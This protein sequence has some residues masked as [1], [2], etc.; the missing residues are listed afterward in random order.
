MK[1]S[2]TFENTFKTLNWPIIRLIESVFFLESW[3]D[4]GYFL[5]IEEKASFTVVSF[6][7]CERGSD[8]IFD[9]SLTSLGGTG[10]PKKVHKFKIIY[11]CSENRQI[12]KLCFIYKTRPQLKF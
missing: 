6:T 7:S 9:A 5:C 1:R 4:T 10:C 12:T 3:S 11:L 2:K 8:I